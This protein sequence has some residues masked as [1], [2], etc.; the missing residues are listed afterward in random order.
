MAFESRAQLYKL[1]ILYHP[2]ATKE[3]AERNE[4]PKSEI[5][6][7][8]ST[9]LANSQAQAATIAARMIPKSH[10]DKLDEVQVLVGPF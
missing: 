8:P 3:Q 5:L 9:I 4:I 10:E 6:I 2:K 7:E 1:A